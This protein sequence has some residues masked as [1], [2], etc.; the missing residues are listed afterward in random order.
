MLDLKNQRFL[1]ELRHR[2]KNIVAPQTQIIVPFTAPINPQEPQ[3]VYHQ[4]PAPQI[5]PPQR[6]Q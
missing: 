2:G 3:T 1:L 6:E 5:V 4:R